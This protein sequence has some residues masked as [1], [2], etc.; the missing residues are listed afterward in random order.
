[1][2]RP[3]R[4]VVTGLIAQHPHLGGVAWDYVQYPAGLAGLGHDVYYFEDSGQWPY[5][6]DGGQSGDD[7]IARDCTPNVKHLADVME[8]FGLG[9]RWAY[10]FPPDGTWYGLD[11]SRRSDVIQT[12]DLLLNVSGTLEHPDRYRSAARLA[13]ID[14]DPVFTQVRLLAGPDALGLPPEDVREERKF[15]ARVDAHDVHFTFGETLPLRETGHDWRPTRQ[16]ILLSEWRPDAAHTDVFTTVMSWTSY[17]PLVHGGHTY[18]QKDVELSRFLDL[19]RRVGRP[20]L[21]VAVNPTSHANWESATTND[22]TAAEILERNGWH[23]LD[24]RG[25]CRDLDSYRGFVESSAGEWSVAKNGYVV[26]RPGWFSC[27]SAC[28]LA[29]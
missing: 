1:M 10:R 22:G 3:L 28:Y 29:A 12:A 19:P 18:A 25:V 21:A 26:G 5:N 16:P 17:N 13:Y 20:P 15:R 4:I 27:R 14:S 23:V 11:D 24:A 8:R 7:W 2:T 9:E 6:L